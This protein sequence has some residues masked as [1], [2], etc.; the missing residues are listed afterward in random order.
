M[1]SSV[2]KPMFNA[3]SYIN[4][5]HKQHEKWKMTIGIAPKIKEDKTSHKTDVVHHIIDENVCI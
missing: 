3:K 2:A 1:E 4:K 5:L